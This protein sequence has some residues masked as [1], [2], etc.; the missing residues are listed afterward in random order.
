M[1]FFI[2]WRP[3]D[4]FDGYRNTFED[5]QILDD[6]SVKAFE[7]RGRMFTYA[8]RL[9][10]YQHRLFVFAVD[11]RG[12]CARLYRFD[13]SC[14]VVSDLIYFRKDPRPLDEFFARYSVLS[15]AQRG[16]DP[17]V[18]PAN[19][20]E[21]ALFRA[22]I[23]DYYRRAERNN[24]RT[25]PDV[26]VLK[27]KILKI[28]VNDINGGIHWY[29]ACK[30]STIPVNILPC[31]RLTRGFIATPVSSDETDPDHETRQLFWLKDC[32]RP[33]SKE[34]EASIYYKLKAKGV[35]N[36]PDIRCAGD[37]LV[38]SWPQETM[39]DTLLSEPDTEFWRR[40]TDVIHH[41]IHHRIVAEVLIPLERV[42]NAKDLLL[43]GRDI[44]I[45]KIE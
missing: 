27:G 6:D 8:A 4:D 25:H 38:D 30:C 28:Q 10:D 1:D 33:D 29:L 40:P 14:V 23:K 16:Y 39:N 45:S 31:G 20:V 7:I 17:T 5:S 41:M 18:T 34:P 22:R 11:I 32:W 26:E 21:K 12:D 35:P 44:L 36:L 9:M 42:E 24:L 43:V 2:E 19:D 3:D 37:V 13:S 15:P